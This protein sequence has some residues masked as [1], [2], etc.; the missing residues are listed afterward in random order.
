MKSCY[1]EYPLVRNQLAVIAPAASFIATV[2]TA[3]SAS[4][5]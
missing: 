2:S 3:L 4:R 5:K 1:V